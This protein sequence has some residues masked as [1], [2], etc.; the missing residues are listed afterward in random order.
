MS[1]GTA[2]KN[3][4]T[5]RSME[6]PYARTQFAVRIIAGTTWPDNPALTPAAVRRSEAAHNLR[7]LLI[8]ASSHR[9]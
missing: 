2:I 9:C 8:A 7:L 6:F 1:I 3:V 4:S 5:A